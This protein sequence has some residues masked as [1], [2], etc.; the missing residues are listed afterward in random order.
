MQYHV[1]EGISTRRVQSRPP[2]S[3]IS[4][5]RTLRIP[6]KAAGNQANMTSH[7]GSWQSVPG[8]MQPSDDLARV[9]DAG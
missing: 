3:W 9:K 1:K 8:R 6:H 5:A 7:R 2:V 4:F